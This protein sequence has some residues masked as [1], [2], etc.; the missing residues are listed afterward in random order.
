MTTEQQ[1]EYHHYTPAERKATGCR[2]CDVCDGAS[3]HWLED[4]NPEQ[5]RQTHACKHCPQLGE[6]CAICDGGGCRKCDGEG[7]VLLDPQTPAEL[8]ER[9][10]DLE[11]ALHCV[12]HDPLHQETAA[13]A[14][15]LL[16]YSFI[17]PPPAIRWREKQTAGF[18]TLWSCYVGGEYLAVHQRKGVWC[19][20]GV[21]H[22]ICD[23]LPLK[24]TDLESAKA[25]AL[26]KL[27]QRAQ[28]ILD[29]TRGLKP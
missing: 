15:Q 11:H 10:R 21:G 28:R 2:A 29:Q 8:A 27:R 9:I 7:V 5:P 6:Q 1:F 23:S 3:H 12:L 19:Y 24:A 16:S 14:T 25:E 4:M 18:N 17:T 20:I 26:D 13:N 22:G